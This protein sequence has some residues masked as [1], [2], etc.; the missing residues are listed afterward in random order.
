MELELPATMPALQGGLGPDWVQTTVDVPR[1]PAGFVLVRVHAAGVNRADQYMLE[2][3]YLASGAAFTAGLEFAGEVAAVGD[4]VTDRAVGD[5]VMGVTLGAFAPF[6]LADARS[7]VVVP[8]GLDWTAA[9]ALPVALSTEFDALV[10]R[11]GFVAGQSVLVVGG[12]TAIGLVG[13]QIAATL[14]ASQVIATTT[15]ARKSAALDDAGADVVV[16]TSTTP[17]AAAV[18]EATDG[19]G[20]DVALDHV[21]GDL[22]AELLLATR[23]Q[24]TI[25]NI[26]R[27]AGPKT[28]IDL[29]QLAYRRLHLVGTTFSTRSADEIGAVYAAVAAEVLPLVD[30][31]AIE[32]VVDTVYDFADAQSAADRLRSNQAIGKIVLDLT[33]LPTTKG[34]DR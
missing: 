16:D 21:G 24:G 28:T 6:A 4:G 18:L 23:P 17:L 31:G 3:S 20:V 12:T 19:V 7:T 10:T 11:A 22:F 30:A 33:E 32:A 25:V 5:R 15:S 27:I 14:G 29:D 26:G 13:I 34:H 8:P 2:G 9:A 1:P